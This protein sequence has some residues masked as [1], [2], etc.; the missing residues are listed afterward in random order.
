MRS[1]EAMKR[2]RGRRIAVVVLTAVA[3]GSADGSAKQLRGRLRAGEKGCTI[4]ATSVS[5]GTYDA[6]SF[7]PTDSQGTISYACGTD[8]GRGQVRTPVKNIQIELSTGSAGTYDRAMSGPSSLPLRYNVYLDATHQTV[9]GDG[10]AGTDVLRHAD[11][12]NNET[13][14]AQIYGRIM[15]MQDVDPGTYMDTLIATIQW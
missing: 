6:L 10:S 13:F 9:W 8:V 12:Q 5:F 15:P 14:T 2:A 4:S 3:Y 1:G 7:A 11:P